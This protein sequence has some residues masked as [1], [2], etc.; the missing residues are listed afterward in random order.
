[1]IESHVQDIQKLKNFDWMIH[2]IEIKQSLRYP[3]KC[4]YFL[5]F[6]I[7]NISYKSHPVVKYSSGPL[8]RILTEAS[9]VYT[10]KQHIVGYISVLHTCTHWI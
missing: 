8:A 7:T 1:M 6:R 10:E 4:Q 9:M 2:H 3:L 5:P